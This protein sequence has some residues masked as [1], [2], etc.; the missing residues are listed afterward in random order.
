MC[1]AVLR[2]YSRCLTLSSMAEADDATSALIAQMLAADYA[3]VNSTRATMNYGYQY[4]DEEFEDDERE[5][6]SRK[7]K[8]KSSSKAKKSKAKV[9]KAKTKPTV[10][11]Q[12]K[13]E[14]EKENANDS[15]DSK[16]NTTTT[17]S[18]STEKAKKKT[19]PRQW[20]PIEE[21]LFLEALELYGRDW[22]K[23]V[24]HLKEYDRPRQSFTSHAQKHFIKLYRDNLPL[25]LK[26]AESGEG[27]TLSGKP[28]DK[29][30]AAA[31]QYGA[32]GEESQ[33]SYRNLVKMRK[34]D[35][36]K[37]M[38]ELARCKLIQF[39]DQMLSLTYKGQTYK[40]D[41][42]EDA[43]I[44][45]DGTAYASPSAFSIAL[46]RKLQPDKKGDNGWTSVRY[47]G[48]TLDALRCQ[49]A[50]LQ[51][52]SEILKRGSSGS[53]TSSSAS[54]SASTSSQPSNSP[55]LD[56]RRNTLSAREKN[57]LLLAEAKKRGDV[58]KQKISHTSITPLTP[59]ELAARDA[60]LE[61]QRLAKELKAK[62]KAEKQ[63][64]RNE[65]KEKQ[66]LIKEQKKK[67]RDEIRL[68]KKRLKQIEEDRKRKIVEDQYGEDG[69]K[70]NF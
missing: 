2:S 22:G 35:P 61:E 44:V 12:T 28:L 56:E 4:S 17:T 69:R 1:T 10:S 29:D 48:V 18:V 66:R 19:K 52:K 3:A 16:E 26:V 70:F 67:E 13:K 40:A 37:I 58:S 33:V 31:R 41:F 20:T 23:C 57:D 21:K 54:S 36:K 53:T 62:E 50:D 65:E 9:K 30:S 45:H 47:N 64:Q 55:S 59:E 51:A 43:T 49:L 38:L 32:A 5:F 34:A 60:I 46:K 8:R 42:K 25:P 7:K 15:K 63:A 11:N 6:G 68:Q 27:Y 24:E 39:G 14:K